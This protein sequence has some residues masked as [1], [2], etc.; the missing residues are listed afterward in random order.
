MEE[1]PDPGS[2]L[3]GASGTFEEDF[4]FYGALDE[5]QLLICQGE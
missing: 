5:R 3:A 1:T 4:G 2:G